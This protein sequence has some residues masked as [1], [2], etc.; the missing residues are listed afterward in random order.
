MIVPVCTY[1]RRECV[2]LSP[3]PCLASFF[4]L[5]FDLGHSKWGEIKPQS[6]LNLYFPY[7]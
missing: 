1:T 7:D 4:H 5:G 3:H 6:T 2:L